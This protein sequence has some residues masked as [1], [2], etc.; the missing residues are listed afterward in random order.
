MILYFHTTIRSTRTFIGLLSAVACLSGFAFAE[1]RIVTNRLSKESSPYLL[2]HAHNPV[3]WYPWDSEALD[4]A[5]KENKLI[6]LSVGYSA[7]HWCH[8]M[9]R[10]SFVDQ[11][12]ANYLNENFVCIKV[13][14]EERPDIDQIYM[15]AIQLT[16]GRSGWPMSVFLT[17]DAK[18]IFGGSYFPARDGDRGGSPGFLS[19]IRRAQS[20]WKSDS[21]GVL[22]QADRVTDAIVASMSKANVQMQSESTAELIESL[23]RLPIQ[24]EERLVEQFDAAYGGFSYDDAN[25]NRPKFP[26]PSNLFFLLQRAKQASSPDAEQNLARKMLTKTLDSMIAGGIFDHFGGGFHRYSTDRF[27]RIPHFEKMLYDNGQLA[28]VYARAFELT[29]RHEYQVVAESICDFAI[30]ELRSKDGAFFASLD[31]DSENEEGKFYRWSRVELDAAAR[32]VEGFHELE[33]VYQLTQAPNFE[34]QFYAPQPEKTLTALAAERSQSFT[35]LDRSL[36]SARRSMASIRSTR[37]RPATDEKI[38]TSW[39]GLMIAGLADAGRIFKREDYIAAATEAATF[40]LAELKTKDGR[41][42]RTFAAGEAKLNGYLDDYAFLVYGLLSLH[43]ATLQS[44][45]LDEATALT[46]VQMEFF[47]DRTSG[48]FFYTSSD[49]AEL[50]VRFHDPVDGAVPSGNSVTAANLNYLTYLAERTEYRAPLLVTLRSSIPMLTKHPSAC[51]LMA[52][53]IDRWIEFNH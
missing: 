6:F 32:T 46:D 22:T 30:R 18:P 8:V 28:Q 52:T 39:N 13:D 48:V 53:Q 50:I 27:W 35:E 26:E 37:V 43:Q 33:K 34:G 1:D 36:S 21:A 49:H 47:Q 44:Q 38:L 42:F 51:P 40:V 31:A 12:I 25:S 24:T 16:S 29:G 10:E 41:L 15:T 11:E 2:Q 9:E 4:L 23:S 5:K 3:D 14:R 20:L 19:V 45:W 7:C 17:P